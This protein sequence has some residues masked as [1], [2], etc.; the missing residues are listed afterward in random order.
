[1]RAVPKILASLAFSVGM[2]AA[3]APA[4]AVTVATFSGPYSLPGNAGGV[5]P[6][7]T[8]A[9][10]SSTYDFTFSTLSNYHVLMQMQASSVNTGAAQAL[11]FTLFSGSPGSGVFVASSA[12][13]ATAAALLKGL[14]SGTYYMQL[15]TTGAPKEL[16][17][18]GLTLLS[19]APEPASWALMLLGVGGLGAVARRRRMAAAA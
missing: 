17:T 6:S 8:F 16:V 10:G 3:A 5:I 11:S 18:G 12:G 13:T 9:Q 7:G 14:H 19:A 15:T 2:A 4:H 1:M